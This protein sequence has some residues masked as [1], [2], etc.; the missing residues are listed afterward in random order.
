M[1]RSNWKLLAS[2]FPQA[3]PKTT[4][5]GLFD[6]QGEMEIPDPYNLDPEKTRLILADILRATEALAK[7]AFMVS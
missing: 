2:R 4:L 6:P 1:D 3:L 7:Q 5:L